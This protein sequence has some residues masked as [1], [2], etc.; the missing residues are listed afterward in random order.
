MVVMI[1]LEVPYFII[2][3]FFKIFGPY[4][5]FYYPNGGMIIV[6]LL[7]ILALYVPYAV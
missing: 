2:G 5:A 6:W 4:H 7:I 1:L 3:E